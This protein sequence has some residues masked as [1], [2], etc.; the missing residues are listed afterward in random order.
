MLDADPFDLVFLDIRLPDGNGLDAVHH[1]RQ[2][3]STPEVIIITGVG[4]PE[5][6]E[7]AIKSGAWDYI[8]K[9]FN[10]EEIILHINRTIDYR[11]ARL[12]QA[13]PVVLDAERVGQHVSESRAD[14]EALGVASVEV[15][16]ASE[17]DQ[18]TDYRD[19]EDRAAGNSRRSWE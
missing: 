3:P 11:N 17:V 6:A 13:P 10:K 15:P 7:M 16:S 4:S 8:Q 12:K 5:R 18:K 2:S 19:D 1:I 9:P 14:V